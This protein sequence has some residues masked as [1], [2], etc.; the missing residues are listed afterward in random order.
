VA[1]VLVQFTD[2]IVGDGIAYTAKACGAPTAEGL[3]QGWLEFTPLDGD[4]VLRS[5][6]ETTQ[7]NRE[8]TIYWAT[9][10]S[11][12]YL[13]GA[14]ERALHPRVR[15]AT[16]ADALPAYDEPAPHAIDG[17]RSSNPILDPFAVYRRGEPQ[18]RRQLEALSD[19]HL[20]SIVRAYGLSSMTEPQ[21]S[22]LS[23]ATLIELIVGA[24][25]EEAR[26]PGRAR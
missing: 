3:W 13:E 22:A 24:V 7:P 4:P 11:A 5:G 18:L 14:L 25:N 12:V 20:V 6:R 10:L 1:E 23:A 26:V 9:G 19:W 17:P 16:A 8:D 15:T 21:L 2:P